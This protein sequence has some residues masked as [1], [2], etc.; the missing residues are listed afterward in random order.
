MGRH[1]AIPTLIG[2]RTF[3]I[4]SKDSGQVPADEVDIDRSFER[5]VRGITLALASWT[6]LTAQQLV[7]DNTGES[8][9]PPFP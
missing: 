1:L 3:G 9:R 6:D 2:P 4:L 5:L 8:D 7:S